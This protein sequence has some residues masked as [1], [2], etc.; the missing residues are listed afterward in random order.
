MSEVESAYKAGNATEHTHRPALK[1]LLEAF[2]EGITATNEP[3][4]IKCGAPDYIIT[5]GGIPVGFVEA[6]DIGIP[7]EETENSEQLLRYRESLA[8]LILTDY[9]EFRWYE[10]GKLRLSAVLAKPQSN[11]KLRPETDGEQQLQ[12]LLQGFFASDIPVISGPRELAERMAAL[13]RLIRSIIANTFT[14]EGEQGSLHEQLDGFRKVLMH[15][16]DAGQFADMYAQTICYGLF[17]ARC[18]HTGAGFN[19]ANAAYDL[20]KTNPFLRQLFGH[21]AGPQLDER[22]V[23]A[24]DSLAELLKR[25]DMPAILKDFGRATL[26]QDPVVHFYETF[27]RA[28]DKK[29][30]EARGVYY[31]PGPVVSYIVRSVDAILKTDF[32]LPAGLADAGKIKLSRPKLKGKGT[33]TFEAH[34]VQILDPAV[35]TGTFLH[36]VIGHI[37]ETL[38]G[39]KGLWT[40]YVRENLLPRLY[41]FELLM[42]PYAVAHMKLGL[43]LRETG[44]DF[45]SD[46]RLRVYLTNTLEEA[47]E[48]TGYP[49]FTQWLAHE[50]NSANEVKKEA[51]IMVVLG[52]PPYSGHSANT[53]EWI[54]G[55][56]RGRDGVNPAKTGDYFSVD[57]APLGERNPKWLNDDYVKFI[58][59]AQWRIE[60]TG[61]GVLAFVTNHGY[62]DNPTFRG[63]RQSLL[64][65]FDDIYILDLHGNS[66]KKEKSPD[67]GKDENVFD[68]QQGVAIGLFVKKQAARS[69]PAQVYHAE[70]YGPRAAKYAALAERDCASTKWKKLTPQTPMYFFIPQDERRRAEYEQGWKITDILPVNSVGIV[71]ARD[72]LSIRWNREDIWRT[73]IDFARLPAEEAREKYNLGNDARDWKVE[74]AQADLKATGPSENNLTPILYRPFDVRHTYYTGNSRGFQCMPRGEVMR[75][76]LAGKNVAIIV[77][78][79][80][81]VTGDEE[82]NIIGAASCIVDFNYYRRGGEQVHPLYLYPDESSD[83]FAQ[84]DSAA[85]QGARRPNISPEFIKDFSA[86]LKLD[87]VPDGKGDLKTTFGPEDIFHYAYAVFYSP[88]YRRRYAEFL[89]TDFPKLPLTSDVKLFRKLC[90][91]GSE[92]AA[93]HLL[94]TQPTPQTRYPVAGNDTV[95]KVIYTAPQGKV[96]GRVW[97]NATQ[98]F[99]NVPPEVWN[100]QI[101]GYQVCQKWLKDRKSRKLS[102]EDLTHYRAITAALS[103]TIELQAEIDKSIPKWP[104]Q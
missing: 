52:N 48:D 37:R 46:E 90:A 98:Y 14:E 27:L 69:R 7:L 63:M 50:A 26:Q 91:F 34:K 3:R 12:T 54:N 86:R 1:K 79:S 89:K 96:P 53:G 32:K 73:V 49:L 33:E 84:A 57:G 40:G 75:N 70:L 77:G 30:R 82:W 41:G 66:K 35:G 93:L 45:K 103:R 85:A 88:G 8:N 56:L 95:E 92:L 28:Y 61:Y 78:R 104:I 42:A 71:T 74:L 62:L 39:D 23:W 36:Q 24:V 55:L 97:L 22:I 65:T 100:Y 15:D 64:A 68:I 99:D 2:A 5:R 17:A 80:G 6:K 18:N 38:S 76:M 102:Y 101:G 19:R 9:L 29:M 83:L 31:T 16:L 20:P 21:I 87:F 25:A 44:Y 47:H 94:E 72:E 67:G 11:G 43:L 13:A 81:A 60:Q 4:R 10:R 58:R 59:F 51:P